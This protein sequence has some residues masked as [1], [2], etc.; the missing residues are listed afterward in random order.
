MIGPSEQRGSNTIR[1]LLEKQRFDHGVSVNVAFVE[2][3]VEI[4]QKTVSDVER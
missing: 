4:R 2:E 3:G 1:L